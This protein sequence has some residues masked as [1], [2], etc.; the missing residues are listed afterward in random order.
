MNYMNLLYNL[1]TLK[2][3]TKRTKEEL[4]SIQNNKL[5]KMLR[6]AYT[7]STYYHEA[8]TKAG[9]HEDTIDTLPLQAFPTID[10]KQ[11]IAE[12]DKIVCSDTIS[13]ADLQAFDESKTL[14]ETIYQNKYHLVHSSGST[15]NPSYFIYDDDAWNQMLLGIIRGALWDMSMFGI[16]K[17]LSQGIK[18]AYIAA[19]DGRYGGA[20]AVGAGI[21]GLHGKQLSLDIN[22]PVSEWI[23]QV[24]SFQPNIIIGYPSAIKILCE[25]VERQELE[26]DVKRVICC[27]EPLNATL[28]TYLE[29]N[30]Q[31]PV[32]NI[33]GASE[34]LAL[35]VET[36]LHG[37]MYLFDDLNYIEIEDGN[38]Y[39]TSLYNYAQPL[40][41]YQISDRLLPKQFHHETS[42]FTVVENIVGRNEDMMWFENAQGER[43]FLHPLAMEGFTFDGM[44]DFQ[45]KQTAS[46][47]FVMYIQTSHLANEEALY[48]YME[49]RLQEI[50]NAK[51]LQYVEFEII[52]VD[53][54]YPDP[55]TGKKK[56]II[57]E[58]L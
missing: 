9:I 49:Q 29:T 44:L 11:F 18:I 35:G 41:R 39:L 27:G 36:S 42:P 47:S 17:L 6:H 24:R 10:K 4:Q 7:H 50:V 43:D 28:R 8:F 19:T 57:K 3:N 16:L 33:Y 30:L 25:L 55:Q 12:F 26:V 53:E 22:L 34:S 58:A 14:K 32:I 56:L 48:T 54:I 23:E 1:Y 13:Q 38:M 46:N 45:F 20:M 31:A 2:R 37:G 5:R 40:I 15:G 21:K 52:I 51:S